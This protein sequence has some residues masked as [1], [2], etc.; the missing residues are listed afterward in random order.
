MSKPVAVTDS[1]FEEEVVKSATPVL[2]DFWAEWCMPCKQMAPIVDQLAD[3]QA[4]KLKVAKVDVD[5][6]PDMAGQLGVMSIPTLILFKAGQPV[7]R[8][9]GSQWTKDRLLQKLAPHL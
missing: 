8:F 6:N 7:E 1:T 2:V 5:A 9:Q 3:E 4:A